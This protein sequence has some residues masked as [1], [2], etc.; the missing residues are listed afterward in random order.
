MLAPASDAHLDCL[1]TGGRYDGAY[2]VL[3]GLLAVEAV[4]ER[5]RANPGAA[6]RNLAVASWTNEEGARFQPSLTGSSV[7]AGGLSLQDSY[8]C[9]D[10]DGIAQGDALATIGYRGTTPL[11]IRPVPYV[12]LLVEQ[13]NRLE[14]AAADIAAV[15]GACGPGGYTFWSGY[16]DAPVGEPIGPCYWKTQ[17]FWDGYAWCVR[18]VR[19]CA[20]QVAP[21]GEQRRRRLG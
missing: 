12:E 5:C 17:R 15:S 10:G 13:G 4:M 8:A 7:L 9:A 2:G 19:I 11:E 20:D 3:A 16:V 6:R 1:P 18:R 14:Q 21:S